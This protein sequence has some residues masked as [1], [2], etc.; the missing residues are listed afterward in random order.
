[1]TSQREFS[2]YSHKAFSPGSATLIFVPNE[3]QDILKKGS[4][5][6]GI[7]IDTG[8]TTKVERSE[9]MDIRFNGIPIDNSIQEEVANLLKFTGRI[10]S[11]SELPPSSGFGLS[12]GAALTTAAAIMGND[13]ISGEVYEIAHKIE[14]QRGT[15]LG[16]VQSQMTG[17]FHVRL[18]GGSFPY[19]ITERILEGP[20]EL[21]ILPFKKK[22]PTGEVIKSPSSL[23]EIV[24]NGKKTFKAFMKKP[25]LKNAFILG[26]KF[27][28][29]SNLV[30][31]K[32]EKILDD[33]SR[34]FAS[35]SLIGDSIIALFDQ[36]SLEV[37][38]K[39]GDPIKTKISLNGL[40]LG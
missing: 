37:L 15:G 33:L 25:T 21:I 7:C 24:R 36:E 35:V 20:T 14:L 2:S 31:P 32:A 16:D 40:T 13:A 6:V 9:S 23:E 12:A 17:G 22:T 4:R 34:E 19:S 38:R 3:E 10:F 39:Y 5:G 1:M 27:A 26:R 11:Y 28:F 8:I 30:S 18:K 29:D